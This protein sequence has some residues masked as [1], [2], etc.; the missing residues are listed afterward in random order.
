MQRQNETTELL[1]E[2]NNF[3]PLGNKETKTSIESISD[4]IK[5]W[6]LL[7]ATILFVALLLLIGVQK[8]IVEL[9]YVIKCM[10]LIMLCATIL[11]P[12]ISMLIDIALGIFQIV[13]F[14]TETFRMLLL[15]VRHD[16]SNIDSI[17][18]FEREN[19]EE[20]KSWLEVKCS[21]I[22]AKIG[23]FFGNSEKIALISLAGFGWVSFKE[24]FNGKIPESLP[25]ISNNPTQFTIV[26]FV[27]FFTGLSIGAMLLNQQLGRYT[28]HIEILEM[29]LKRK[30]K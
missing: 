15:E 25:S 11:L 12:I 23:L 24:V 27:A 13:R 1:R 14:K 21:R 26:L 16:K 28:Y 10:A 19:L 4:K 22:K 17:V 8:F 20:V 18:K 9:P 6:L 5:K 30:P 3:Q 2:L 29:A 7:T